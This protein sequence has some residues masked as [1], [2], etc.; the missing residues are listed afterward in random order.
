[1]VNV[2]T[3][4]CW[5]VTKMYL[6]S[7]GHNIRCK[8]LLAVSQTVTATNSTFVCWFDDQTSD[9]FKNVNSFLPLKKIQIRGREEPWLDFRLNTNSIPTSNLS[10]WIADIMNP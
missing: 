8:R 7:Y 3:A 2:T 5:K 9:T 4:Q 10:F 6:Y 1:M